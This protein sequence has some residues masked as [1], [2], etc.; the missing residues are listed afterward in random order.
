MAIVADA[1]CKSYIL[2]GVVLMRDTAQCNMTRVDDTSS[3]SLNGIVCG[4]GGNRGYYLK[5]VNPSFEIISFTIMTE[6]AEGDILEANCTGEGLTPFS[7][8]AY[9]TAAP[10][11]DVNFFCVKARHTNGNI[12]TL[13]PLTI[14]R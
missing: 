11:T 10:G 13:K 2:E 14:R 12:Y 1:Q 4:T 5:A 3:P 9:N 8:T 7:I 6:N